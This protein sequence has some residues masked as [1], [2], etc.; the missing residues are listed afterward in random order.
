MGFVAR[1]P[2]RG[3]RPARVLGAEMGGVI[4]EVHREHGEAFVGE[5]SREVAGV[6]GEAPDVVDHDHTG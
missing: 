1:R 4:A 3:E 6:V 5:P 2:A